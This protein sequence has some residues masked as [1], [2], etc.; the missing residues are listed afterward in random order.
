M[1]RIRRRFAQ[2]LEQIGVEV[3]YARILVVKDRHA[4]GEDTVILGN[5]TA[6]LGSPATEVA[7]RDIAGRRW[8]RRWPGPRRCRT[9]P[10][11]GQDVAERGRRC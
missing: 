4:V 1:S 9:S 10:V 7:A 5:G 11:A 3:G 2:S 8:G 6:N